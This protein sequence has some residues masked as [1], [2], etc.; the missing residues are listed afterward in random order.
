MTASG[1]PSESSLAKHERAV[2]LRVRLALAGLMVLMA[3]GLAL[4]LLF[5]QSERQRDRHMAQSRLNVV[6][7]SR[8]QAVMT[9][10]DQQY[11]VLRGLAEN[12]SVQLYITVIQLNDGAAETP[13]EVFAQET[14][15]RTL[16]TATA[17]RSGFAPTDGG[18]A[19]LPANVRRTGEAGLALV[20]P[21]GTALIAATPDMPPV[22]GSVMAALGALPA[23][24][25]G[26]IDL[27]RSPHGLLRLGFTVPVFSQEG[28]GTQTDVVARVVGLR[29]VGAPFFATLEQ[30]GATATTAETYLIRRRGNAI[31]Y[32]TPLLDGSR[33]LEKSLAINT[34]DL[35]DAEALADPGRFHV[36]RDYA[37]TESFAVSRPISGTDWVLV[38]RIARAEALAAADAR[39]TTLVVVLILTVT[40]MGAA[41]VAVWRYGTSVRASD[42]A[43]R[44]RASSQKFEAL[45]AFLDVVSD[46]Q[47][48]PLFV[49]TGQNV[50]TF[51][52]RRAAEIMGVPKAELK[53]RS[54]IAMLGRDIGDVYAEI[55]R[56]VL[57]DGEVRTETNVF[58]DED[59]RDIVWRSYHCPLTLDDDGTRGVLTSI[60]DLSELFQERTRRE[61]NTVQLIETLVGLVDERDPDSAHQSRYV[62]TVAR[63]I[64]EE[65]GLDHAQ[66]EAS[67]QAARLVNIGKIRVPRDLLVK[68]GDLTDEERERIRT[69][70][71][72]GPDMLKDIAFEAPVLETL[73]QINERVDGTGRPQGLMGGDILASAQ[74]VA[75]A[76]TFVALISPRAFRD[77]KSFEEAG[78]IL[79]SEVGT[80]FDRRPVL[81]LLNYL[82]NKE[83]K[84]TW[85]YMAQTRLR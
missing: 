79:M 78:D 32:L 75:V 16:L 48:S 8:T 72:S 1:S 50:L 59:D 76:N 46:S 24:E 28:T 67:D 47:P 13:D 21:D 83:G 36:G 63:T 60:D 42:A 44:F 73:R 30:P 69:A 18:A 64:A 3:G 61:Q 52:N 2:R 6:A 11:S 57:E 25:A 35:I 66:I 26:L 55:N 27:E 22:R 14:Y 17:E 38:H 31:E 41:L 70:M 84:T 5:A 23:T 68:Q 34:A 40:L 19:A 45:S 53:G 15:L 9:W 7:D 12:Q 33:P 74:A 82:S 80:R 54:L 62:A 43:A 51:G 49:A 58:R 4:V 37:A 65:M 81:S 71:D 10:L 20:S 56:E 85:A 39:R 29:P 77:G